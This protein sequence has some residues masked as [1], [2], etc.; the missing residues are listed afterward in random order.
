MKKMMVA[1]LAT[2]TMAPFAHAQSSVTLY[3]V[4]TTS[5]Q[6]VNRMQNTSGGVLAP[7]SG[8]TFQMNSSGIAQ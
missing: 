6:Y 1:T 2:A 3:G 4:V 8:S 7:G 5:L